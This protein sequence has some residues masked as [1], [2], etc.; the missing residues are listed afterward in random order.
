MISNKELAEMCVQ[1]L[2]SKSNIE[3]S[4]KEDPADE[5]VWD[6]SLDKIKRDIDY[7]PEVSME[8]AIREFAESIR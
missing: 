7:N 5:Y 1:V 3:F 6:A 4:G 8:F 2:D